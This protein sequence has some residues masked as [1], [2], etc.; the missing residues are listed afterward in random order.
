MEQLL[1]NFKHCGFSNDCFIEGTSWSFKEKWQIHI[2]KWVIFYCWGYSSLQC[3]CDSCCGFVGLGGE[4][5]KISGLER[6]RQTRWPLPMKCW[7]LEAGVCPLRGCN[8]NS[9]GCFLKPCTPP[10][11]SSL[12]GGSA[13]RKLV[14]QCLAWTQQ[15]ELWLVLGRPKREKADVAF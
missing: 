2:P 8:L 15:W 12:W 1:K 4:A 9:S 13:C 10:C 6:S 11:Y 14:Q 5:E 7:S 3:S